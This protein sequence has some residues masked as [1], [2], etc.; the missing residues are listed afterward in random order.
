MIYIEHNESGRVTFCH[1]QPMHPV[2]GLGK[3]EEELEQKGILLESIPTANPP[4]GKEAFMMV[5]LTTKQIYFDYVDIPEPP[6]EKIER[7]ESQ[8]VMMSGLLNSLLLP[9]MTE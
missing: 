7:L 9:P 5:D 1:Y 6:E 2:N 8:I 3:T 4:V